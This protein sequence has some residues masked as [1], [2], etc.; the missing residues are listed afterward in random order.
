ML[1]P[2]KLITLGLCQR[3]DLQKLLKSMEE[4]LL[5]KYNLKKKIES[6]L[7]C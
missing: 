5:L 1:S 2:S 6:K 4:R 3:L 7:S